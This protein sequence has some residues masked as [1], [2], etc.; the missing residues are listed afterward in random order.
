[1]ER[2]RYSKHLMVMAATAL[3]PSVN[4]IASAFE[5]IPQVESVFVQSREDS[6]FKVFAV[7]NN[8]DE[9]V[10]DE[11]FHRE[12]VLLRELPSVRIDFNVITR[13]NRPIEEFVGKVV[14]SWERTAAFERAR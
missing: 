13:R 7:V 8:E 9:A 5:N 12:L 6:K 14:P 10:Y 3:A 11:I 2:S 4:Q 1:M